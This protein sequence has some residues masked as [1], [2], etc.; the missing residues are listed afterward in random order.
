MNF[1]LPVH[2]VVRKDAKL[3]SHIGAIIA[4]LGGKP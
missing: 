3:T 4:S 1:D 2:E